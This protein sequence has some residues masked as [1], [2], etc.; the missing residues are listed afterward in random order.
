MPLAMGEMLRQRL[1]NIKKMER[2]KNYKI[3]TSVKILYYQINEWVEMDRKK[4][5]SLSIHYL[6][7]QSHLHYKN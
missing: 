4:D 7:F 5:I 3:K 6:N 2:N 1:E